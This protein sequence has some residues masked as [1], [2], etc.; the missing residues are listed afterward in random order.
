MNRYAVIRGMQ[1]AQTAAC[2]RLHDIKQRLARWLLM[3]QDRVDPGSLPITHDFLATM[4]GTDR[5]TVSLAAGVLQK[6]AHR[7]HPWCSEN[8][9]PQ[10]TGRL[11]LRVLHGNP[12][13]R[14]RTWLE[15]PEVKLNLQATFFRLALDC[16]R[17]T[18]SMCACSAAPIFLFA[19]SKLLPRTVTDSSSQIP[20]QPSSSSPKTAVFRDARPGTFRL[21][22][23][24]QS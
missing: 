9:K 11:R 2:N 6:E 20:F 10:E 17:R 13:V 5:S 18:L 21:H 24:G 15:I 22:S 8:R 16:L 12:T 14:W 3:T 19:S 1:V 4:L 7:V 23:P